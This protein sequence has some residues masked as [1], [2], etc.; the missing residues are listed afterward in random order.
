[1]C[2][3]R[4]CLF[5]QESVMRKGGRGSEE[6]RYR[7]QPYVELQAG[8][9]YPGK[10]PTR[11]CSSTFHLLW[12]LTLLLPKTFAEDSLPK[13]ISVELKTHEGYDA[14]VKVT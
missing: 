5:G 12:A 10:S 3:E 13:R 8:P 1:M 14:L 2:E 11:I 7:V 4:G 6:K 9:P